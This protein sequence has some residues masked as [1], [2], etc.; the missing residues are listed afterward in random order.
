MT[1]TA[2][3]DSSG[4]S[5]SHPNG[6]RIEVHESYRAWLHDWLSRWKATGKSES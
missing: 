3:P 2:L 1:S 5:H 6:Q 4:F